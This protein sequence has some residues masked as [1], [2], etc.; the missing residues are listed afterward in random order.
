MT[1]AMAEVDVWITGLM[2]AQSVTRA[3][4]QL[5]EWDW[6]YQLLKFNPLFRW[7]RPRIWEYIQKHDVPYNALH[8]QGYPTVGCTHCTKAVEGSKPGEY[9]R[10]GRW[11]GTDKTECG[12]HGGAGI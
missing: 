3:N 8:E 2:R 1:A 12:L 4:L 7:D 10:S 6:K 9:S 11:A 5:M